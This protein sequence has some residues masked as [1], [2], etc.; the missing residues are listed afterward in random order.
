[1]KTEI[2]I[3]KAIS[4]SRKNMKDVVLHINN[5]FVIIHPYSLYAVALDEAIN[6]NLF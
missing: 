3:D 6:N 1:M 2:I 4:W 5:K